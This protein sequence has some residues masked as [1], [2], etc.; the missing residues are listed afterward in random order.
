MVCTDSIYFH[1]SAGRILHWLM[2]RLPLYNLQDG[3]T[4]KGIIILVYGL[5]VIGTMDNVF[6]LW[7]QRRIGNVH[8]LITLFGVFVGVPLFGFI[9]LIF[10]PLLIS[11][12]IL[13]MRIYRVEFIAPEESLD[14]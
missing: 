2:F 3:D 13:L 9:G 5:G 14:D 4:T 6:R 12:F 11:I 10:G 8:P 1:A 7:L